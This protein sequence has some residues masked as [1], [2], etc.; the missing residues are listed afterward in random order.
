MYN[1]LNIKYKTF[2]QTVVHK[3]ENDT[4]PQ[5]DHEKEGKFTSQLELEPC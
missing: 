3:K 1:H 5:I 4:K 2:N